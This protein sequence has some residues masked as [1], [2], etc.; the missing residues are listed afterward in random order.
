MV[1]GAL[2][3]TGA[4]L[5]PVEAPVWA[6]MQAGEP[7]LRLDSGVAST[8]QALV[9]GLLGGFRAAAADFAWLEAY[10]AAEAHDL[11]ATE[12]LLHLV[13]VIDPRPVYFWLNGAR[14]VACDLPGWRIE[15]AGGYDRVPVGV[16]ERIRHDQARRALRLLAE[17]RKFHP[18]TAALWIEQANIELT[19]L[20]DM[21]GAAESYRRAWEQ[22]QAPYF[23]ARLHAE[24]LRRLGRKTEALAWL[25]QLHPQLPADDE[26]AG[27]ELVLARIRDLERELRLPSGATYQPAHR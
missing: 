16:Q 25:V 20:G 6:Q 4:A 23:A 8:E 12:S 27:A 2:A 7:A 18:T 14:I 17:G 5:R 21:A 13:T 10:E 15:A 11:P 26:A 9:R 22:P 24:L 1:A 3:A 19:Q